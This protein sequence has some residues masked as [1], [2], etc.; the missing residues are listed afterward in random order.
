MEPQN[1]FL[2][3]DKDD[4]FYDSVLWAVENDITSG[5]SD[6]RFDPQA[7]CSRGQDS[8][9][10]WRYQD[11]PTP[12]NQESPFR[13]VKKGAYYTDAV[14]WAV[15]QNIT[16]GYG[17]RT[18]R[19]YEY[20]TRAHAITFLWRMMG[21]PKPNNPSNP[22]KDVQIGFYTD[23]ALWA[24]ENGITKGISATSFA[25]GKLCTRAELLTFLYRLDRINTK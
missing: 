14:L 4:Y 22:F 9:F 21:C 7:P 3:V 20:C 6:T 17:D 24:V 15:E 8:L 2:D 12:V 25:P 19:P 10:L 5:V 16:T 23:A 18:F 13:D 1:P 11:C